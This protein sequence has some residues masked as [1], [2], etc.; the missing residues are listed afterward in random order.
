MQ[1]SIDALLLAGEHQKKLFYSNFLSHNRVGE[2][3]CTQCDDTGDTYLF[4][5]WQVCGHDFVVAFRLLS[6][7]SM[8]VAD[9]SYTYKRIETFVEEK[10]REN[11]Q[12]FAKL[13]EEL[14]EKKNMT[15][16]EYRAEME[17]G[18]RDSSFLQYQEFTRDMIEAGNY[19][20]YD[21]PFRYAANVFYFFFTAG[22]SSAGQ[23]DDS[24]RPQLLHCRA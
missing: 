6:E 5:R 21:L 4:E 1:N 10:E 22:P 7:D 23:K 18:G 13:E 8:L 24:G 14:K 17:A 16:E 3:I 2:I 11:R 12:R 9:H 19:V 15:L 20:S